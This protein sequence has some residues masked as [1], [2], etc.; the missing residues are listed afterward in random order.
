MQTI[1]S[2][3][4]IGHELKA[5]NHI[6]QRKIM[7]WGTNSGLDKVTVMHGWIIGFIDEHSDCDIYQKDIESAFA[8]SKST[9]TNILKLMEKKGYIIRES[10]DCDARLKK[11]ILTEKGIQ[12][13]KVLKTVID[14]NE[15]QFSKIFDK[16]EEETFLVLLKK[17]KYG[18]INN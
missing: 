4:S 3:E 2:A 5:I 13:S 8:I 15:K 18:L 11:L 10:V 17:L 6:I 7:L 16:E 14:E 1:I 12:T 9:V